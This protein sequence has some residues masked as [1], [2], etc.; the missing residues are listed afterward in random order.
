[1]VRKEGRVVLLI[2]HDR[3]EDMFNVG[4]IVVILNCSLCLCFFPFFFFF[5]DDLY[6]LNQLI[7]ETEFSLMYK[8]N[9]IWD[10]L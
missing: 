7:L 4:L 9:Q 8:F 1:M 3:V 6:C 2:V 5:L 10:E